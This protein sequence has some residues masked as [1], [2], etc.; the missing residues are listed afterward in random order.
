[1][2]LQGWQPEYRKGVADWKT[3][4]GKMSCLQAAAEV[5]E[6]WTPKQ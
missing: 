5:A 3:V 6:N 1:M 2:L 4:F